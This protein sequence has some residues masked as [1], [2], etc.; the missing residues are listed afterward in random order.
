MSAAFVSG[1]AKKY[2][3]H[4]NCNLFSTIATR[5]NAA[6]HDIDPGL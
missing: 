6:H 5:E 4:L 3:P 1:P 2:P